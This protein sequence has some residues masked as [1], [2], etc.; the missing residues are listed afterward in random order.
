[1]PGTGFPSGGLASHRTPGGRPSRWWQRHKSNPLQVPLRDGAPAGRR[2][3]PSGPSSGLGLGASGPGTALTSGP[4]AAGAVHLGGEER[5]RQQDWVPGV[6]RTPSALTVKEQ[7]AGGR[8]GAKATLRVRLGG[9]P[10][11]TSSGRCRSATS[12]TSSWLDQVMPRAGARRSPG[13][14]GREAGHGQNQAALPH[15]PP[16]PPPCPRPRPLTGAPSPAPPRPPSPGR[17]VRVSGRAPALGG[18]GGGWGPTW[19]TQSTGLRKVQLSRRSAA[20]SACR[21]RARRTEAGAS[22]PQRN[23]AATES[24]TTRRTIPRDSSTG[25]FL[26]THSSSASC[27]G[28]GGGCHCF[29]RP[30]GC[31]PLM[32]LGLVLPPGPACPRGAGPAAAAG[33]RPVTRPGCPEPGRGGGA[34]ALPGTRGPWPRPGCTRAPAWPGWGCLSQPRPH[35]MLLAAGLVGEGA[36]GL[37]LSLGSLCLLAGLGPRAPSEPRGPSPDCGLAVCLSAGSPW[38]MTAAAA[39]W[40]MPA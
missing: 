18:E 5:L 1:M 16:P 3:P 11:G 2:R 36:G 26:R 37:R 21:A 22:N 40:R 9:W 10:R 25:T 4:T 31:D 15:G 8:W 6:P 30:C 23:G 19:L 38:R 29:P 7:E 39:A 13:A 28:R 14:L 35:R 33:L 24:M 34:A 27:T 12:L 20:P 17:W 32:A